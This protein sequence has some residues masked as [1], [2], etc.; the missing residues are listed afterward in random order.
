M[1][2]RSKNRG[3]KAG[4]RINNRPLTEAGELRDWS[5]DY[6]VQNTGTVEA[7]EGLIDQIMSL[8]FGTG[9]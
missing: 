8:A 5:T 2:R 1:W 7:L 4:M 3:S 6:E 9:S